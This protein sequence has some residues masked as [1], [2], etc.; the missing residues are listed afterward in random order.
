MRNL[1]RVFPAIRPTSH[2]GAALLLAAL[3]ASAFIPASAQDTPG[4]IVTVTG[5]QVQGALSASPGAVFK[6]IPYAQ[7][8]VGNLRW[9]EP[10]PVTKW[11]GARPATEYGAPCA[12]N[13][14]GWNKIIA[15]KSSEDCLY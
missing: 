14:A 9:R 1:K 11:A 10:Q 6:G 7:P 12:Q 4:P 3:A 5:G 8:P 13:G 15:M 2:M